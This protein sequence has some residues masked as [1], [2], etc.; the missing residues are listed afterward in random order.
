MKIRKIHEVIEQDKTCNRCD[1]LKSY[2]E[3]NR[4]KYTKGGLKNTCKECILQY[5]RDYTVSIKDKVREVPEEKECNQCKLTK[6]IDKFP[7]ERS[8]ADGHKNQCKDCV[9]ENKREY[10]INN[11]ELVESQKKAEYIRNRDRYLEYRSKYYKSNRESVLAKSRVHYY[12]NQDRILA[13]NREYS[14]L[15]SEKRSRKASE[16]DLRLKQKQPQWVE[17]F[18]DDILKIYKERQNLDVTTGIKHHVDHIIPLTHI[19]VCGLHVPWNMQIL[20][21]SE[22]CSKNNQ[23]DG[24]YNNE[25]WRSKIWL[26][27]SE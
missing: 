26:L 8:S 14:K 2:T 16:R 27:T 11:K 24:T 5:S 10:V 3:Y 17:A 20:T 9:L 6:I 23:F 4:C 13:Y 1:I 7:K 22:N 18:K 25:S 15:N 19:E 12:A 21:Q